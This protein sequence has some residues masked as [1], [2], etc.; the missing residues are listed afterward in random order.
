MSDERR[1]SD[2]EIPQLPIRVRRVVSGTGELTSHNQV[3]CLPRGGTVDVADCEECAAHAGDAI[4]F[5]RHRNYVLCRKVT[6]ELARGLERTRRTV[7][8]GRSCTP[9]SPAERTAVSAI[10]SCDVFCAREDLELTALA[11]LLEE[12]ALGGLPVVDG[13]GRPIGVISRTDLVPLREGARVVGDVMSR[14]VFSL[15][16]Q[17][18]IAEAAALMALEHVHRLPIVGADDVLVGLVSSHDVVAWLARADGYVLP[19]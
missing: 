19:P 2:E 9:P 18:S 12:R 6:P 16:E 3:Y 13:H 17:A 4:D 10:M 8:R 14:L 11:Q 1:T 7:L 5:S 15:P